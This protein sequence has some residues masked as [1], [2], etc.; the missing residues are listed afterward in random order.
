M[1]P[2]ECLAEIRTRL[3][4]IQIYEGKGRRPPGFLHE[5]IT[6]RVDALDQWLTKGG[7]LPAAW[8]GNSP[9]RY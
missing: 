9:Q 1:D 3:Q 2:D 4:Q 7:F 8:R 6:E 5:E